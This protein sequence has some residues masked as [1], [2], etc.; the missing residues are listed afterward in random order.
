MTTAQNRRLPPFA[1]ELAEILHWPNSWPKFAGTSPSGRRLTLNIAAGADAWECARAL[2]A[3]RWLAIV[4][5]PGEPPSRLDWRSLAGHDPVLI[6]ATGE[7]D[8]EALHALVF[9]VFR[10]GVSRIITIRQD[11]VGDRYIAQRRAA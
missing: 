2:R 1:R 7:F 8:G 6:H 9:A 5:P 11:R 4:A 3:A 10:D